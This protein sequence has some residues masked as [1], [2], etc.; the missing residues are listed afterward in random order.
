MIR[1]NSAARLLSIIPVLFLLLLSAA[2]AQEKER[3]ANLRDALTS[4]GQLSGSGGPS[5]VVW[6]DGGDRYSY[7]TTNPDTRTPE[8]RAYDPASDTDELIF[9]AADHTFPGSDDPFRY[10]SFQWSKDFRFLVFQTNFNPVY[11]FSGVSDYYYYSI[12]DESFQLVAEDAFTAELSP[13]GQKIAYERGGNLFVFDLNSEEETQLTFDAEERIFNGR[14]GWVYEE[15]FGKAQA[16]SWSHDSRYIAYWQTDEREVELFRSTDYEGTYPEYVEIPYPKVGTK[17]P[18][19]RIGVVN[20]D[21]ADQTWMDLDTGDGYIPRIYWTS[22]PGKLAI[23]HFNRPQTHLK[24]FFHDVNSGEGN[25]VMEEKSG[26]GW[27]DV[28]DFFAGIDDLFFFP[29]DRD[30]FLWVSDRD[31]WSHIYRYNY[32][33]EL[34]NR[35][36]DGE[37]EVT[38]VFAVDSGNERI[39]YLSTETSAL[40]RHL[41]SVKF[42]GKRKQKLTTIPG[43]HSISMGPNGK[44]Y[45]DRYSNTETPLQVELW[46]SGKGGNMLK[47]LED[48]QSVTD[49]INKH[50]YAPREL[51][52]FTTSDGQELDGYL[53]KPVDFDP[54]KEYP[55]MLNIYGGPGAQG[56]Y[57][58]FESSNWTQY[59]AQEGYVI[60]NV[61]NRGSGGYGREFEKV[62]Y[63]NLGKW[64]A[65]DFAETAKFLA[66]YPWVDG[67][68]MAIRGH[69]YGGYMSAM[70]MVLEPGVFKAAIAGAPVTDWRLYDTIYTE[71]YMGLLEENEDGYK[72]SSVTAHA[73]S[74]QGQ[75]LVAHASMDENVHIQNTM[76]MLTAFTNAG[77]DVDLR[78]YPPGTHGVA[79]NLNSFILLHDTYTRFLDSHIGN[80]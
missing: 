69:S 21:S 76:Q 18:S 3:Y 64:E 78:I 50:V 20:V 28:F 61:N 24:L 33:G 45:I 37:W 14:F 65:N 31:G 66:G 22:Q 46:T 62:V 47:K 32:E 51:F 58:Q 4:G 12:E 42:N 63:K 54:E 23:V 57:N 27:I 13:D 72:V 71:R 39:F 34:L 55:L 38:N 70:T 9:S 49:F 53:I 75:L 7:S 10:R 35:V 29:D 73:D 56:V 25:M 15:E 1:T 8:I 36:T 59:L 44:Y 77:K 40:E 67:D 26:H 79:Y 11:R 60:A 30:E 43:R 52:S 16:W 19:V 48:N 5:N 17:N 6:I 74:L 68:R 41:Y 2:T 80:K